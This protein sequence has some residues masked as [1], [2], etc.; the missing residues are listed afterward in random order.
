MDE[1][2]ITVPCEIVFD[3]SNPEESTINI[4]Y[5]VKVIEE[6]EEDIDIPLWFRFEELYKFAILPNGHQQLKLANLH[7]IDQERSI[8]SLLDIRNYSVC[9]NF[10][11]QSD[12]GEVVQSE[13]D[14]IA[15]R[16]ERII[17]EI[18]SYGREGKLKLTTPFPNFINIIKETNAMLDRTQLSILYPGDF[19]DYSNDLNPGNKISQIIQKL[20]EHDIM[21]RGGGKKKNCRRSCRTRYKSKRAKHSKSKKRYRK[22]KKRMLRS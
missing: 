22:S 7:C 11:P 3:R 6:G 4:R 14:N 2:L 16:T 15:G 21:M 18:E 17:R 5:K 9:G 13:F 20:E 1:E 10:L 19:Y 8:C 12:R